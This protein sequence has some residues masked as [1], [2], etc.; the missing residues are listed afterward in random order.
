MMVT[1]ISDIKATIFSQYF[2]SVDVHNIL[3]L[4][5]E[6]GLISG[7]VSNESQEKHSYWWIHNNTDCDWSD[8][9]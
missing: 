5:T 3:R 4:K 2:N 7:K 1:T 9:F 6:A 8:L